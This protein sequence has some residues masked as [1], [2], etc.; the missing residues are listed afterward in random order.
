MEYKEK[1]SYSLRTVGLT[2]MVETETIHPLDQ[3]SE[4]Y[5]QATDRKEKSLLRKQYEQLAAQ[6]NG[7]RQM[8]KSTIH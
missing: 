6:F 4:A 7:E 8:F 2:R 1:F 5:A 3:I